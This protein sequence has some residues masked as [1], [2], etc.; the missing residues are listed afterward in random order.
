MSTNLRHF[1]SLQQLAT[2]RVEGSGEFNYKNH[3]CRARNQISIVDKRKQTNHL[4]LL[5]LLLKMKIIIMW[6]FQTK[7]KVEDAHVSAM[8]LLE[9]P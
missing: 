5:W 4:A 6:I 1:V 9:T 2:A 8:K 7:D 3:F